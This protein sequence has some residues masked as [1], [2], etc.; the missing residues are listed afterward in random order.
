MKLII[1]LLFFVFVAVLKTTAQTGFF[2]DDSRRFYGGPVL[3]VNFTQVDGDAYSGY[4]KVGLTGGAM[5]YARFS[6]TSGASMEIIYSQKGSKSVNNYTNPYSGYNQGFQIYRMN[7]NYVEVP[8]VLH[9]LTDRRLHYEVGALYA[10]LISSSESDEGDPGIYIDP[11]LHRFKQADVE[12]IAGASYRFYTNWFL[13][14]RIQYSIIPIRS[15]D[16]IPLG[17]GYGSAGQFNNM[18]AFRL[19][20]LFHGK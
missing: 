2:E 7:L 6:K 17:F 10:Q 12:F 15:A 3:G 1:N 9:F 14:G 4:T 16:Q 13:E 19:V 8:I 18:V 11:S 20:Y 5:V